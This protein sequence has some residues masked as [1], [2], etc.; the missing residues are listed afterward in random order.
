MISLK[1][2][3]DSPKTDLLIITNNGSSRRNIENI[4][5]HTVLYSLLFLF[6]LLQPLLLLRFESVL[7]HGGT[8]QEKNQE[9]CQFKVYKVGEHM[10]YFL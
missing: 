3:S 8:Y 5:Q 7:G 6:N 10:K 2:V 1:Q 4:E 9:S